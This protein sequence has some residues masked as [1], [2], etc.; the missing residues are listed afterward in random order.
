L[1]G[2][3][4][5]CLE[6]GQGLIPIYKKRGNVTEIENYRPISLTEVNRKIFEAIVLQ[7][8]S[9][10]IT[11]SKN[12]GGF[13]TRRGTF[14]VCLDEQIKRK[15]E[16]RIVAFL[17]IQKAYDSV[18]RNILWA[19]L[20]GLPNNILKILRSLFDYNQI[21]V[22]VDGRTSSAKKLPMGLLQGSILSPMLYAAFIDDIV[23]TIQGVT[24]LLYA[25]DIALCSN[26]E[27]ELQNT[28]DKI[29]THARENRYMYNVTKCEMISSKSSYS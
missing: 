4:G 15:G 24:I 8:S 19:K 22:A 2:R 17:D 25:D 1:I 10:Y 13:R 20:K 5:L 7:I 6:H 16:E 3:T 14:D 9:K 26:S 18:D 29:V 28:L 23:Q 11:L 21:Q 12:Q 27:T